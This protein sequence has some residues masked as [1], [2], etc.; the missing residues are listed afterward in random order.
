MVTE[1]VKIHLS[2]FCSCISSYY[3]YNFISNR[4]RF[5]K[6]WRWWF[7]WSWN[8]R[9][10]GTQGSDSAFNGLT[11]AGGGAA[12]GTHAYPG[13]PSG[14]PPADVTE[15]DCWRTGGGGGVPG[16]PGGAGNSPAVSPSQGNDGG[17]GGSI[18]T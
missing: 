10:P 5:C 14:P 12:R 18:F 2:L 4:S 6:R 11:S 17:A 9:I 16:K 15:V 13:H 8:S 1:K 3:S 7:R